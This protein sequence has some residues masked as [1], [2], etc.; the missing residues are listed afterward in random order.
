MIHGKIR[1]HAGSDNSILYIYCACSL[2]S[3]WDLIPVHQ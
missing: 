1:C 3:M 2:Q